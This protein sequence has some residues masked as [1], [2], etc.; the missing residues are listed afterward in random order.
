MSDGGPGA[1]VG[2]GGPGAGVARGCHARW[3]SEK[4]PGALHMRLIMIALLGP[5]LFVGVA[6][7]ADGASRQRQ[8][9]DRSQQHE[10]KQKV[11]CGHGHYYSGK[12][13]R[14]V[15]FSTGGPTRTLRPQPHD[16][17]TIQ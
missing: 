3:G 7:L 16:A 4:C 6:A 11:S 10:C 15:R 14:V 1:D 5:A 13:W 9:D 8:D 17:A 12:R 2:D